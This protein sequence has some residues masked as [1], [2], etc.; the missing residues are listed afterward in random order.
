M[1]D[2]I[3][4]ATAAL[5][6]RLECDRLLNTWLR[7]RHPADTAAMMAQRTPAGRTILDMPLGE[8][9]IRAAC[10]HV[11]PGGF[12]AFGEIALHG[13]DGRRPVTSA[14]ELARLLVA[15]VRAAPAAKAETL[16]RI[17]A[18]IVASRSHAAFLTG[19][20]PAASPQ[21]MEQSL[22]F[23]HPFHPLAKSV[24][25]FSEDDV[26]AYGPERRA[27]F[28]LD[29]LLARRDGVELLSTSDADMADADRRLRAASGLR[30]DLL[31]GRTLI[32]C[33]PWQA[34]R[35]AERPELK[36]A[37]ADGRLVLTEPSGDL[38]TPTSS[39]RTVW[40]PER[41]LYVKLALEARITNFSRVNTL[42]Q[43][44]RS[45]AGAKAL[46]AVKA[47]VADAGLEVLNEPMGGVLRTDGPDGAAHLPE[48]GFLLRDDADDGG[49][50]PF[51]VAG[52]FEPDPRTGRANLAAAA[53]GL[54][55]ASAPSFVAAY[56]DVVLLPL[57][58]LYDTTGIALEA[59]AQ[60][61]LVAF[62]DGRPAR[63]HVRDLEGVAAH[64]E[65]FEA[66]LGASA[67]GRFGAALFY[68][69]ETVWRRLLY[70]VVVNH[71]AHAVA[72]VARLTGAVEAELWS[73]ARR[74]LEQHAL[75][76]SAVAALL[77]APTLPAKANLLSCLAE[78]GEQPDYA[79]IP[80]PLAVA[81]PFRDARPA[82]TNSAQERVL[83]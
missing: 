8:G 44:E 69:R 18:S 60:N 38:A 61:S 63:L 6:E 75:R 19:R 26:A 81:A 78:R 7:E 50:A 13:P 35:L 47:R 40:F 32:P 21:D 3:V 59:H 66:A 79:L 43:I 48:T 33:H 1:T 30:D 70:Y 36:A 28:Q 24:G 11:S 15:E 80:N 27:R 67:A 68:D 65:T 4:P 31:D 16:R 23:G 25:G 56:A 82:A 58:T 12:H 57:L 46:A 51:V 29:W 74:R 62:R 83:A 45:I 72:T 41:G 37:F 49:D 2:A 10:I 20:P 54:D 42:D 77:A 64:R 39:V 9:R 5:A 71:F 34:T 22:W 52:L 55:R 53:P 73:A 14:S 17:D 76:V